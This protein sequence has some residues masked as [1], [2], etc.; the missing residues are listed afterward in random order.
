MQTDL[1]ETH[2]HENNPESQETLELKTPEFVGQNKKLFELLMFGKTLT[3]FQAI[4]EHG[5]SDIRRR[6][7]D[8][9]DKG[10]F[11]ISKEFMPGT[12]VKVWY[13]TEEQ[14]KENLIIK[15][16]NNEQ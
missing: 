11:K 7:K 14:I 1:F 12:R 8:L 9:K 3:F 15:K 6:A 2:K 10:G 4:T 13:M 16:Q 5:I